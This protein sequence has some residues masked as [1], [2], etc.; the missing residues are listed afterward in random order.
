MHYICFDCGKKVEDEY[1]K[2]KIRCPYCGGKVLYKDRRTIV[3]IKARQ[4]RNFPAQNGFRKDKPAAVITAKRTKGSRAE[5]ANPI[6]AGG[7]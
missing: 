6:P 7:A 3:K 4:S 2:V 5:A 1:T